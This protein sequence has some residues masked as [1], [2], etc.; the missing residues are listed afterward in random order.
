MKKLIKRLIS[1]V[2]IIALASTMMFTVKEIGVVVNNEPIVI[3]ALGS[4]GDQGSTYVP[5][6]PVKPTTPSKVYRYT[7][8]IKVKGKT[9]K[10][11]YKKLSNKSQTISKKKAF[12]ISKAKGTVTFSK[13]SGNKKITI[14]KKGVITVKKGLKA[15]KYKF[16]AKVRASGN[17]YYKSAT[18]TVSVTIKVTPAENPIAVSGKSVTVKGDDVV[19]ANKVVGRKSAIWLK[20]AEGDVSYKKTS[21]PKK[22][23]VDSDTGS[24]TVKKG[25]AP[26]EYTVKV[27][28]TAEGTN[29]YKEGSDTAEVK[30][31]VTEPTPPETEDTPAE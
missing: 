10:I 4:D 31:T 12:T 20:A 13:K 17:T 6:A 2:F 16:K 1:G 9:N 19:T 22:I 5:P 24:L 18:K 23:T 15:G 28:V 26:G 30:I 21:G 3:E 14:S 27:K 25:I 8:P 11:D 7:N 29:N